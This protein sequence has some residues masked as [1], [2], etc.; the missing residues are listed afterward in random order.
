MQISIKE[1][2]HKAKTMLII[3]V[4]TPAEFTQGHI[5]GAINIPIFSD[6]ER[7]IVGTKYKQESRDTA[8]AEAMYFVS[9]KVDFYLDEIAKLKILNKK[10]LI[11]CWRGGMRSGSMARLFAADGYDI[12]ILE[13]GYKAYRN[14]ILQSF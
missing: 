6:E 13:G 3:D 12:Q 10:I 11:H 8:I 7:A 1:F 5:P 9:Q 14:H 2:L 4:R